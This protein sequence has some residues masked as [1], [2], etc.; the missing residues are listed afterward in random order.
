MRPT[1]IIEI[2][3]C[4]GKK[5]G[6]ASSGAYISINATVTILEARKKAE[7][8]MSKKIRK[9]RADGDIDLPG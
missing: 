8:A 4:F 2:N 3:I 5:N 7:I 1:Q 9:F 6:S